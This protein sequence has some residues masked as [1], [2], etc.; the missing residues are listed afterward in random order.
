MNN[1]L[2][3]STL[4]FF[5]M[6]CSTSMRRFGDEPRDALNRMLRDVRGAP[7]ALATSLVV[8]G[9]NRKAHTLVSG[10]VANILSIHTLPLDA[11]TRL[12]GTVADVLHEA[13]VFVEH[14]HQHGNRPN[15]F[16]AVVTDGEDNLSGGELG[17]VQHLSAQ[18]RRE[19]FHL[20]VYGLGVNGK[21][22]AELMGFSVENSVNLDA[23]AASVSSSMHTATGHTTKIMRLGEIV[24]ER[25]R[26][27]KKAN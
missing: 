3:I 22:L 15:V 11:G 25:D 20:E 8:C 6:D 10:P 26:M 21:Y 14:E 7:G 17:H 16:I 12:F 18:A 24:A 13:L 23:S 5:V 2:S 9:F 4:V 27:N 19:G 1:N